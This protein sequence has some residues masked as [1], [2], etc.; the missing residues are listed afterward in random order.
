MLLYDYITENFKFPPPSTRTR[1][2]LGRDSIIN[3]A[4]LDEFINI[5]LSRT[6][7]Q[8][9]FR[10]DEMVDDLILALK[11]YLGDKEMLESD[12]RCIESCWIC[13]PLDRSEMQGRSRVRLFCIFFFS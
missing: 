6:F 7:P 12:R 5:K 8:C 13:G 1:R 11:N 4:G 10:D 9:A 2:R 3:K